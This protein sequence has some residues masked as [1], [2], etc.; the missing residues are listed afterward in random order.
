MVAAYWGIVRVIVEEEQ[1]GQQQAEYV[2]A[3]LMELSGRLKSDFGKGFDP[4]NLA[5]MRAFHLFYPILD[6]RRSE[7]T[8]TH[9]RLPSASCFAR[10][11]AKP[12]CVTRWPM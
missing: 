8:W 3:L 1:D 5:K 4:S 6:A 11:K 2:R 9:Y 7:L 10:T 12:W